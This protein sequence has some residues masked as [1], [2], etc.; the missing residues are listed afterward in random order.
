MKGKLFLSLTAGE[1]GLCLLPEEEENS[2]FHLAVAGDPA[3][4]F[5]VEQQEARKAPVLRPLIEKYWILT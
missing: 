4:S 2:N 5:A 3:E 1:S